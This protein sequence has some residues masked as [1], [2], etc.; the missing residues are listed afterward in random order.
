M[1]QI[2]LIL[3]V[4]FLGTFFLLFILTLLDNGELQQYFNKLSYKNKIN[5]WYYMFTDIQYYNTDFLNILKYYSMLI[6]IYNIKKPTKTGKIILKKSLPRLYKLLKN[7]SEAKEF[8]KD[9]D[10]I[11]P[12]DFEDIINKSINDVIDVINKDISIIKSKKL[13]KITNTIKDLYK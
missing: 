1:V 13:I 12:T 10:F 11:K 8:I 9:D 5:E 7:Y 6:N 2:L 4:I 3:G